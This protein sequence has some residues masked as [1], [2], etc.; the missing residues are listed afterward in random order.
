MNYI[1]IAKW[2]IT[3]H[4][5]P[6]DPPECMRQFIQGDVYDHPRFPD[7]TRV[8]TSAIERVEGPYV[9]T[10]SGSAYIVGTP[11][12]D[13]VEWCREQGCHVPTREEPIRVSS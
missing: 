7:G 5:E 3:T 9:I 8:T 1:R 2:S 6:Y 13:Y 10:E 12:P 11:D 4:P